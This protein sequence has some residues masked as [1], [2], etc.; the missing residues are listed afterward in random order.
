MW[1]VLVAGVGGWCWWP[2]LVARQVTALATFGR[3]DNDG[4][5]GQATMEKAGR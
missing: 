5:G 4:E 2:V 1:P 3:W